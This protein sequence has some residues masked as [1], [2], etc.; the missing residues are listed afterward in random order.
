[1]T[2]G[3]TQIMALLIQAVGLVCQAASSTIVVSPTKSTRVAGG[4]LQ[5]CFLILT[6]GPVNWMTT[7]TLSGEATKVPKSAYPLVASGIKN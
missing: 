3:I 6:R 5:I 2:I 1:M 7:T 4:L